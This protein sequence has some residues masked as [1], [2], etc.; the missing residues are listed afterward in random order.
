MRITYRKS[1]SFAYW[2]QRW[3]D[4]EADEP[5][6]N[7]ASY[8]LKYA[9]EAVARSS[10]PNGGRICEAG[11]GNGRLVRYF[12][13]NGCNIRGFDFIPDA[14]SKIKNVEPA[15]EV[16]TGDILNLSYPDEYFDTFLAFG[17][18]HSLPYEL[19]DQA[20][21]ETFRVLKPGG[22]LCASFRADNTCTRISDYL[23]QSAREKEKKKFHKLN[24]TRREWEHVLLRNGFGVEK[25]DYVVNMPILY[26]FKCFRHID[27]KIFDEHKG[28]REGYLLN[29]PGELLWKIFMRIFPGQVCNVLVAQARKQTRPA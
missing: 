28:R 2:T 21:R 16:E 17:L 12:M 6:E 10:A 1:D 20:M 9:L 11:C 26:K 23:R 15:A 25:M 14:I 13:R 27:H 24:L 5:M 19:Q 8:P 18:Y 22:V 4:V 29:L 7:R 3:A